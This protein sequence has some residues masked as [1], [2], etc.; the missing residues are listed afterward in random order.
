MAERGGRGAD[1]DGL[2]PRLTPTIRALVS[3]ARRDGLSV[4][5]LLEGVQAHARRHGNALVFGDAIELARLLRPEE[6]GS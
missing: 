1:A 2:S 4:A 5:E 3:E 6:D